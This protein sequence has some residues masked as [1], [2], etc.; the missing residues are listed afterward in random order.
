MIHPTIVDPGSLD[1]HLPGSQEDLTLPGVPIAND[2]GTPILVTLVLGRLDVSF[3]LCLQC[4]GEHP[5]SSL[6][7]D[8]VEIQ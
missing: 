5:A 1:L 2:Q 8:L 7:G 4:L 3:Y 6:T